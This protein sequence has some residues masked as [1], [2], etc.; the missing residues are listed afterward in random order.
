[1]MRKI[2]SENSLIN[3]LKLLKLEKDIELVTRLETPQLRPTSNSGVA[4]DMQ[5]TE[6]VPYVT[7]RVNGK[8]DV[9]KMDDGIFFKIVIEKVSHSPHD[10]SKISA[11]EWRTEGK[12]N[13]LQ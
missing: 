11:V 10:S 5:R 12:L 2:K 9:E 7:D 13:F 6:M 1:M 3:L 8:Y 4:S